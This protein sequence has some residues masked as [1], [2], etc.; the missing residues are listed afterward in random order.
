M[1]YIYV[2][3]LFNRELISK[4]E[5]CLVW[6]CGRIVSFNKKKIYKVQYINIVQTC[7]NDRLLLSLADVKRPVLTQKQTVMQTKTLRGLQVGNI[8][9][10]VATSSANNSSV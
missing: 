8:H 6:S 5:L 9:E 2:A 3:L 4:E 1:P 10:G 7:L